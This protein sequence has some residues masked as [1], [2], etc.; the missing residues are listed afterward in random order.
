MKGQPLVQESA[1]AYSIE[2]CDS[3]I[4]DLNMSL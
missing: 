4:Q 3:T 2:D 1:H